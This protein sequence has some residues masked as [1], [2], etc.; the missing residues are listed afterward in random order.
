M[1]A[2][3]DHPFIVYSVLVW[4]FFFTQLCFNLYFDLCIL[5]NPDTILISGNNGNRIKTVKIVPNLQR[6]RNIVQ[7]LKGGH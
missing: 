7:S 3:Q 2:K 5:Y 4:F 6:A 1:C